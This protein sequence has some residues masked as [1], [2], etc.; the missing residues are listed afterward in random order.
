MHEGHRDEG[1][2]AAN[3]VRE[4]SEKRARRPRLGEKSEGRGLGL[5]GS[6]ISARIWLGAPWE[7][8]LIEEDRARARLGP[9]VS[10]P[11][12]IDMSITKVHARQVPPC[13]LYARKTR[14]PTLCTHRSS[15]PAATPPSRSTS[16]PRKVR[17]P[18]SDCAFIIGV[19][20]GALAI[21]LLLLRMSSPH[22][23]AFYSL[24]T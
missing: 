19:P 15:T 8:G 13:S 2:G 10:L 18:F 1:E 3:I 6:P 9:I 14:P 21:L 23:A 20:A 5:D 4:N 22:R 16:T 11:P 12:A 7:H 17:G 24:S